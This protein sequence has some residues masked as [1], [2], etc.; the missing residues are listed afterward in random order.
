[1][2]IGTL[3]ATWQEA[4]ESHSISNV[5]AFEKQLRASALRDKEKL[6]ALVGSNYQELL[7]TAEQIVELDERTRRAEN[8]ISALGQACKIPNELDITSTLSKASVAASQIKL[9]DR[10]L[11]C[12][13]KATKERSVLLASRMITIAR[14]LVKHLEQDYGSF[15]TGQWLTTRLKGGRQQLLNCIDA[16]FVRPT[17]SLSNLI[18]AAGAY[19]LTTSS[20][21][22]D[23]V[24]HFYSL[25]AQRLAQGPTE[26]EY[27]KPQLKSDLKQRCHYFIASVT[28][29]KALTGRGV[30]DLLNSLQKHPIL[31]DQDLLA[32]ET[33]HLDSI[34]NLLPSDILSFTPYFKRSTSLPSELRASLQ[35]WVN[36]VSKHLL[37]HIEITI[38]KSPLRSVIKTRQLVL[39]IL[40]PSCFSTLSH[41][42]ITTSIRELFSARIVNL[43]QQQAQT[44]ES[45][46]A[47][48][49]S[50]LQ[51]TQPSEQT[52]WQS[53]L[54]RKLTTQP[55]PSC[56][57]DIRRSH[58]GI[59][60]NLTTY[61]DKLRTWLLT[62][63]QT[64][65]QIE[66]L[67][68]IRWQDKIE[69][70]DE[71]DEEAAQELVSS[72]SK[73]DPAKYLRIFNQAADEAADA[74]IANIN[75]LASSLA[76]PTNT[77]QDKN[78]TDDNTTQPAKSDSTNSL[79]PTQIPTLLRITRETTHIL[80]SLLPNKPMQ[81][82]YTATI[83]LHTSLAR[84]TAN[85]L[86]N[87]LNLPSH[88]FTPPDLPSAVTT[89]LLKM[90]CTLMT[91]T[92]GID[93]WTAAATAK[94]KRE[95][96]GRVMEGELKGRFV[97]SEFDEAYLRVALGEIVGGGVKGEREKEEVT[98]VQRRANMYWSRTKVLFG[99]LNP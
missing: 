89:S 16:I 10:L 28:A 82:L 45:L 29:I 32:I 75:T 96:L 46:G 40:L 54:P 80:T 34:K 60:D 61:L 7:S 88:Q 71:E 66:N 12:A 30:V 65:Q 48:I 5:K 8:S 26:G 98:D 38:Q 59:S 11:R 31:E 24:R 57:R 77:T 36:E 84:Y 87:T 51:S 91:T 56:L 50:V 23:A 41:G 68:K 79:T 67:S 92:G 72:L 53:D 9:T 83:T 18:Q 25:R 33:L 15:K 27:S 43:I 69:E 78:N 58:L 20:S 19:C 73:A 37:K 21:S 22:T 70:Y 4:L 93:I 1:M 63:R 13:S 42:I 86:F 3:P 95:V 97:R 2:D 35:Q 55:P 76:Q 81:P 14:L 49:S 99:G 17:T 52:I 62:C 94:L 64:R 44:L 6:R 47:N 85:T 74:Y 90:L 39:D